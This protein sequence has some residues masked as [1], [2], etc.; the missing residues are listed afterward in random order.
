[1][2]NSPMIH[3]N[4]EQF[5]EVPITGVNS[6]EPKENGKDGQGEQK[7]EPEEE[8]HKYFLIELKIKSYETKLFRYCKYCK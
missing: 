5:P 1:M 3:I 8:K 4:A 7:T 6:A 2:A